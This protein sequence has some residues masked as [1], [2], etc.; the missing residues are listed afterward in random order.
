MKRVMKCLLLLAGL[1]AMVGCANDDTTSQPSINRGMTEFAM[2]DETPQSRTAG[3]YIGTKLKFYWTAQDR[4]WLNDGT[5]MLQSVRDNLNEQLVG[6]VTKVPTAKFLFAGTFTNPT[7]P[8]RYTGK[9]GAKDKVTI[10]ATQTQMLPADASHI[11]ESGDCGTATAQ[12]NGDHYDFNLVH[13]AAY[14][15]L[16][17]FTSDSKLVGGKLTKIKITADKPL[18]GTFGFGDSGLDIATAPQS[19]S[20]SIT[21]NIKGADGTGFPLAATSS[22]GDNS[23]T[24]VLPPGNYGTFDIEYTVIHPV[25]HFPGTATVHYTTINFNESKNKKLAPDVINVVFPARYLFSD[26]TTGTLA[27]KGSRIAIGLVLEEKTSTKDGTA[28]ALDCS[29]EYDTYSQIWRDKKFLWDRRA[30]T[31]QANSTLFSTCA[32]AITDMDGY[33][34]TWEAAGSLDGT[35]KGNSLDYP[36]FYEAGHW[37]DQLA[38]KGITVSGSM[39]GRKWY[40]PAYGEVMKFRNVFGSSL[41]L[42]ANWGDHVIDLTTMATIDAAFTA[43]GAPAFTS[44][45]NPSCSWT[46]TET[47]SQN[48]VNYY[49]PEQLYADNF[50]GKGLSLGAY[51]IV[52]AFVHF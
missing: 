25:T 2:V 35:I 15:T 1:L 42:P 31:T 10:A 28:I 48:A 45:D 7:Y 51:F 4:L 5:N 6:G 49:P 37:G 44:H 9:N 24:I 22:L 32:A 20:N 8:L 33:K 38:A 12:K 17:P 27:E 19:P 40:L 41:S 43:V 23:A 26:G 3:E 18:A 34:Y 52:F 46:S 30:T 13:K 21:L 14:L 16:M 29:K 47:D 36:A 50:A 11:G 39:V